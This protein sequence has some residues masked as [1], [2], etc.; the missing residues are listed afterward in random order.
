MLRSGVLGGCLPQTRQLGIGGGVMAAGYVVDRGLP[1]RL[2]PSARIVHS[3]STGCGPPTCSTPTGASP[4]ITLTL[5]DRPQQPVHPLQRR[6]EESITRPRP[7]QDTFRATR[8][9]RH[10]RHHLAGHRTNQVEKSAANPSR[11]LMHDRGPSRVRRCDPRFTSTRVGADRA[12]CL[13]VRSTC[14]RTSCARAGLTPLGE[15]V[16]PSR[17]PGRRRGA[18]VSGRRG[19]PTGPSAVVP[20]V[21]QLSRCPSRTRRGVQPT[22]W[23]PRRGIER[24]PRAS[25]TTRRCTSCAT[26]DRR[27]P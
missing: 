18:I 26:T 9:D 13:A 7:V 14:R 11:S 15:H 27:C 20:P 17:S 19:L 2:P 25:Q 5:A 24:P 21:P 10:R 23:P 1:G 16:E 4:T 22:S 6:P 8:C 12:G 3:P